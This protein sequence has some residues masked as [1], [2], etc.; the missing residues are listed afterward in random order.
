MSVTP[1][2]ANEVNPLDED[3]KLKSEGIR[4]ADQNFEGSPNPQGSI[5][6]G[7][8]GEEK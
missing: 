7:E 3:G 8:Q 4:F 2:P 6:E 5:P 1:G